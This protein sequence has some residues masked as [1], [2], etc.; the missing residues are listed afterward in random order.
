VDVLVSPT[1]RG[2]APRVTEAEARTGFIDTVAL[3]AACR[4]VFVGNLLGLP[5]GTAPVGRSD[6]GLPAGLQI[7]GDAW[8]EA[9]VLQVLAALER[10]GVARAIRPPGAVDL[11]A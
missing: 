1:T 2:I 10:A 4:Y 6:S 9:C 3:D 8:D 5:A 11:L 7:M